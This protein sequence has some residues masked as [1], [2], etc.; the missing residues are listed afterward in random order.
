VE[1]ARGNSIYNGLQTELSRRFSHGQQFTASYT[2]SKTIDDGPGAFGK[3]PQDFLN[4]A[5]DRGLADADVRHRF[6]LSGVYELPF[7]RGRMMGKNMGRAEDAILGGWQL[8]GI[9]TAQSGLLFSVGS[10]GGSPGGRADVVGNPQ[11][12]PSA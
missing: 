6:V 12:S 10:P 9:W 3:G 11:M 4:L 1:A 8:N 2:L 7:G 5:L